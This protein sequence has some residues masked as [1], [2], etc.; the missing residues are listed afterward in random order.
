MGRQSLSD[1]SKYKHRAHTKHYVDDTFE[2]GT[3][4]RNWKKNIKRDEDIQ[5]LDRTDL[6]A[7]ENKLIIMRQEITDR[8]NTL[9]RDKTHQ[10]NPLTKDHDDQSIAV[11]NDEV[12]EDLDELARIE[13]KSIDHALE[14][15]KNGN[16]G[17]CEKC[18][19][20]I[21][22]KRL[23]ALPYATSCIACANH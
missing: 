3:D 5:D 13:L 10:D 6:H 1:Q 12:I 14:R 18:G 9:T 15:I 21:E 7:I 17:V 16:F 8:I 23:K 20:E 11:E 4:T 2:K 19:S 22:D